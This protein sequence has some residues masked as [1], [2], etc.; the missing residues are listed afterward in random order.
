MT[1]LLSA[2]AWIALNLFFLALRLRV[3]RRRR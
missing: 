3:A 2:I 1:V